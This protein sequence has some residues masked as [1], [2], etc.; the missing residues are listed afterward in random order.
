VPLERE[1]GV[2]ARHA[3]PVVA[4]AHERRAAVLDLDVDAA[5]TRVERVLAELLDDGRRPLD[6]LA[7]RDLVDEVVGETLD[8]RQGSA[9]RARTSSNDERRLENA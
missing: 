4:D 2:G 1:L 5:G 3:V 7:G 6:H 9:S 8:G